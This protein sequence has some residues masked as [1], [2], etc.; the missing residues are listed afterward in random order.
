MTHEENTTHD[1][2]LDIR[3]V[4]S[5]RE[6]RRWPTH[7]TDPDDVVVDTHLPLAM[8]SNGKICCCE[9]RN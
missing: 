4:N 7:T 8:A 1:V 6:V 9:G 3:F 5:R 2:T